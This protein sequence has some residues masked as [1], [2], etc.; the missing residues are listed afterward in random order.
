MHKNYFTS[1][2][3]LILFIAINSYS[4]EPI[5]F[6]GSG[7]CWEILDNINR[8]VK[9][10]SLT[11]EY[12]KAYYEIERSFDKNKVSE[13]N[14]SQFI[15]FFHEHKTLKCYLRR[16]YKRNYPLLSE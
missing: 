6:S 3:L 16:R 14:Y 9:N 12:F 10:D 7:E 8:R 1:L 4:Q 13:L 2:L 11:V 15:S 5:A